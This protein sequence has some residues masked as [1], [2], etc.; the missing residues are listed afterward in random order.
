MRPFLVLCA[1]VL[2]AVAAFGQQPASPRIYSPC[3]YGCGPYVPLLT[4][5]MVSLQTISPN[6][7]GA[8]NA[9]T[10]LVAGATNSTLSQIQGST[11]SVYTEAVWYQG[12]DAPLMT[13]RIHLLREPIGHQM[14]PMRED[15]GEE[16]GGWLYFSGSE[17]TASAAA[18]ASAAKGFKKAAHVYT[19]EDVERQNQTNGTVKHGGKTEKM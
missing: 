13:S 18:A 6:P 8:T 14:R 7:V 17:H 19:N 1:V 4:T 2:I 9:T 11:S 15:H 10:G 12:G 16:H 3:L 5:P